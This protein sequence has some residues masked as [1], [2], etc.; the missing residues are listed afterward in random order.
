MLSFA[1]AALRTTGSGKDES[2]GV[3]AGTGEGSGGVVAGNGEGEGDK[4]PV[5]KRKWHAAQ[6]L[7]SS[8]SGSVRITF[9]SH[10][11]VV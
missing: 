8:Q 10:L 4:G 9:L 6:P 5:T 2:R 1:L 7:H 3:V 11:V